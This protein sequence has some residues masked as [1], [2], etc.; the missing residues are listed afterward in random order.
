MQLPRGRCCLVRFKPSAPF[1]SGGKP[2]VK[3]RSCV[4]SGPMLRSGRFISTLTMACSA[5][6]VWTHARPTCMRMAAAGH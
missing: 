6:P 4:S 2:L 5:Q 1:M 3:S